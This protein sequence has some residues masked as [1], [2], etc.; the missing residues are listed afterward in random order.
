[1]RVTVC[2]SGCDDS[3][4]MMVEVNDAELALLQCLAT[5]SREASCYGRMPS[6][7]IYPLAGPVDYDETP[8][9]VKR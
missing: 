7:Q 6:M 5:A 9:E 3:T 4:S 8:F 1:M 2:L